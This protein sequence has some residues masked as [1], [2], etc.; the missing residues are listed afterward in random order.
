MKTKYIGL[1]VS[2][3]VMACGNAVAQVLDTRHQ[4]DTLSFV[5]RLSFRTNAVD[6]ALLLPNIG[7][8]FDIRNTNW[9]RWAVGVSARGNWQTHHHFKRGTVYNLID[10]KAEVRN[11]WRTKQI[12]GTWGDNEPILSH[13]ES[14]DTLAKRSAFRRYVD[15][16]FSY[17]RHKVKRPLAVWYRGVYVSYSNFSMLLG[18][19]GKQGSALT[20]GIVYGLVKPLY[21]FKNGNTLD[22]ELG[23][24]AGVCYARYDNYR[25]SREDDCYPITSK[26]DWHVLPYPVLSDVH[27]GFIYRLGHYP[28]TRKY[29]Y[30]YDVDEAYRSKIQAKNDSVRRINQDKLHNRNTF[31]SIHDYYDRIYQQ[32]LG[33]YPNEKLISAS[34]LIK[35]PKIEKAEKSVKVEKKSAPKKSKKKQKEAKEQDS[36]PVEENVPS[37]VE[38]VAVEEP[39]EAENPVAVEED[40][41]AVEEPA[42][43]DSVAVEEP[44][45]EESVTAEEE[46]AVEEEAVEAEEESVATEEPVTSEEASEEESEQGKEGDNEE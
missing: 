46:S 33:K 32:V 21:E 44:A 22:F 2:I 10:V 11:Y 17:R 1:L 20:A 25:H 12:G 35:V 36:S 4:T 40:S 15:K 6:W 37:V 39:A 43:E 7:V 16:L 24:S 14:K 27:A 13:D 5:E 31:K 28:V 42:V 29:R 26:K 34:E 23:L 30:R 9:N 8:E 45:V 19:K 41:V 38:P 18:S 3:W